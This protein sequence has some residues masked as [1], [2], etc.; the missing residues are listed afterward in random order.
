MKKLIYFASVLFLFSFISIVTSISDKEREFAAGFLGD[1]EIKLIE[2]VKGLSDAQLKF[3]AAP[4]RWSV[5]ECLMHIAYAEN[6]LWKVAENQVKQPA[7]P[8]LRT[9]IKATDEQVIS[10]ISDRTNKVKTPEPFEPKNTIFKTHTQALDSF[11]VSRANL[12]KYVKTT[13]DDLRNHIVTL[14][15]AKFDA[16]QMILFI[17]A[18]SQRHT[19]QIE[20]IKADPNFPKN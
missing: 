19:K 16:Y 9:E 17:G 6:A 12:V 15:F 5:E 20:E 11:K 7:N 13:N 3:K 2:T 1:A 14:P 10:M 18:H 8:D 4:D